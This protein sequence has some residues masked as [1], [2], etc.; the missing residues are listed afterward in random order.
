MIEPDLEAKYFHSGIWK[1]HVIA[2]HLHG[3]LLSGYGGK[4]APPYE[5]FYMGG[6]DDIRGF[7]S[8]S[9]GPAGYV[10]E[11]GIFPVLNADGSQQT[12]KAFVNSVLVSVPVTA[13]VPRYRALS[14]GG[15]TNVVANIE[16]RVPLFG[17]VSAVFF[18]DAGVN[19]VSLAGQ[20]RVNLGDLNSIFPTAGFPNQIAVEP[21]R[22]NIRMSTGAEIQI[23]VPKV[24]VP[25][26][27]YWACNPLAFQTIRYG[28]PIVLD[29]SSL[30]NFSTVTYIVDA[31]YDGS[32]PPLDRRSMFRIAVGRTF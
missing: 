7:D 5:R 3:R 22:Q 2:L 13:A 32:I 28:T 23:V 16:Y 27:F 19:R 8:W 10:G 18:D 24:R 1:R 14:L 21:D 31:L 25:L 17:P 29:P 11:A 30:H 12:Q 6:E 4:S 26:R 9:I 15:D 20:L